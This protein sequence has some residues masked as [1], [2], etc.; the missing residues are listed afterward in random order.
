M[1]LALLASNNV[2]DMVVQPW[3]VYDKSGSL[4]GVN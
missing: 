3:P 1:F 2:V 4:L